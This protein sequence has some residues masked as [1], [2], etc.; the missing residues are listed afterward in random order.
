MLKKSLVIPKQLNISL[1]LNSSK[2]ENYFIYNLLLR[3][4]YK[5]LLKL[6][7]PAYLMSIFFIV[8]INEYILS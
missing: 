1:T 7:A 2:F 5:C 4:L 8:N 6:I 3:L